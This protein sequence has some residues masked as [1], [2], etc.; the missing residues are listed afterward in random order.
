MK[1][2]V[3]F[4]YLIVILTLIIY[5]YAFIK[6]GV[7]ENN[8]YAEDIKKFISILDIKYTIDEETLDGY[9]NTS[10]EISF[11]TALKK[12]LKV[13]DNSPDCKIKTV[14]N[15]KYFSQTCK[16]NV[17][18]FKEKLLEE[19]EK[20]VEQ[21]SNML[22]EQFDIDT[23]YSCEIEKNLSCSF[24]FEKVFMF[25]TNN[26]SLEKS[27]SYRKEI[28]LD[29]FEEL[30]RIKQEREKAIEKDGTFVLSKNLGKF[31]YY[32]EDEKSL[33]FEDFY[34]SIYFEK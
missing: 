32:D 25:S 28:A 30:E 6:L 21:Y 7:I 34:F 10:Y 31:L 9:F 8:K 18:L 11:N 17:D 33:K 12:F 14:E 26:I 22:K 29:I 20:Y 13:I 16:V 19:F 2:G 24:F 5:S 3:A 1:K 4:A 27:Y 15:Q 23:Q